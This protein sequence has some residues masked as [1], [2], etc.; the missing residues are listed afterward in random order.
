TPGLNKSGSYSRGIS[1]GNTQNVFVN[2]ALNLQLEGK[3]S[4][5][6]NIIAS[7]TDQ[8]IPFQPEGNTQQLQE[9]DRVFITL[10]HRRWALT[11]GD[12]VLRNRPSNFLRFYKNVQGGALEVKSEPHPDKGYNTSVAASLAKGKFASQIITQIESVQG[13]YRL[14]GQGGDKFIIVLAN[15]ERVYLDGRLLQRGFDFDYVID[16]N[17]A[18]ITF[19]PKHLITRNSRIRVDFEYSDQNYSRSV[20]H[21][22]HYQT[23]NKLK[24]QVNYYNEADNQNNPNAIDLR[25]SQKQLLSEIGDDLSRSFVS[26]ADSV[27]FDAKQV[28]YDQRD[29]LV[30]GETYRIFI[31]SQ[32][33]NAAFYTLRF[34][35]LGQGRGNYVQDNAAV[36]GRVYRWVAPINGVPQGRYE[37]VRQ[38]PLPVK[39]QM[40]TAGGSYQA[41]KETMVYLEAAA[42]EFDKNRFSRL[43]ADDDKGQA[44]KVGYEMLD[45]FVPVLKAYRLRSSFNYEFTRAEFE[46][47]DRYRDIEF[48][49]DWSLPA[50]T[51]TERRDDNIMNF[52]AG[53]FKDEKNLVNYRISRRFRREQVNGLQHWLDAAH[54]FGRL[55]LKGNLFL[56]NNTMPASKSEWQRGDLGV[57]YNMRYVVPGYVYRFDQN[58]LAPLSHPDSVT[59]SAIFFDEHVFFL[60]SPDTANFRYRLDYT[61]RND[62]QP[63]GGELQPRDISDTYNAALNTRIGNSQDL[64]LLATYREVSTTGVQTEST[65]LTKADWTGDFLDRHL[66]SELSYTVATGREQ[67]R[68]YIFVETIHGQG[69]HYLREGGDPKNLND[70]FEAKSREVD[71]RTHIKIFLP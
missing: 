30:S 6:I 1:F 14:T 2:S 40:I 4:E 54:Q 39:K 16:Y 32:D 57:K 61:R 43:D 28:L 52:S 29:T 59:S 45:K 11:G 41:D 65:V 55:E 63:V 33:P 56:L 25:Q 23:Q 19:M 68:E 24:F 46:P 51:D 66:R 8:N 36:N 44:F 58:K 20:T 50:G 10:Q 38:L 53:L 60:Q 22:S 64:N 47:I 27:A 3:L 9:F 12:I 70:Y 15:S 67:K 34:S 35:D 26:G 31:F 49:R 37:P 42:S 21:L 13:P 71:R 62:K 48:D 69:T 7:V 5:E 17:Q 18:E